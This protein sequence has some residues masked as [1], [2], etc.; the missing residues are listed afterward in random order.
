MI[1][2]AATI[3]SADGHRIPRKARPSASTNAFD[4]SRSRCRGS[5]TSHGYCT[6][7]NWTVPGDW[8][9][10]ILWAGQ[11]WEPQHSKISNCSFRDSRRGWAISHFRCDGYEKSDREFAA[12]SATAERA[13]TTV[14]TSP[15]KIVRNYYGLDRMAEEQQV[16]SIV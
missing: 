5:P 15:E 13:T 10:P 1:E 12:T 14:N 3:I 2:C 6:G 16:A 7:T 9:A 8:L 4:G 11:R